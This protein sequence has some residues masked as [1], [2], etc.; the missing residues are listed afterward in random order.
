MTSFNYKLGEKFFF[1]NAPFM[2]GLLLTIDFKKHLQIT[3]IC[4]AVKLFVGH[5]F[6]FLD[7]AVLKFLRL[8]K[9]SF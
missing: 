9:F 1:L 3:F 7:V 8:Q 6:L 2:F 4:I 5:S